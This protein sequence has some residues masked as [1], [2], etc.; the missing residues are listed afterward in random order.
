MNRSFLSVLA[1]LFCLTGICHPAQNQLTGTEISFG[2][3][4]IG[5]L[6]VKAGALSLNSAC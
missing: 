5:N 2:G 4:V 3:D 6:F 1:I